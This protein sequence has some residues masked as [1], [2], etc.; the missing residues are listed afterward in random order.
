MGAGEGFERVPDGIV[1][2]FGYRMWRVATEAEEPVFFP[3]THPSDWSGGGT[4]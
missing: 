2:L 3:L 4:L 1:P